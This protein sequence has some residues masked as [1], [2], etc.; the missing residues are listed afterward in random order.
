MISESIT[1]YINNRYPRWMDYAEYH[2]KLAG[3]PDE[4][5][6]ILNEV[7]LS[8]MQKDPDHLV[9]LLDKKKQGYTEL[10]F[11]LLA[12]IKL[13][14]HSM[15]SPYRHKTKDIP[16]DKNIDPWTIEIEDELSDQ[17]DRNAETLQ[18][19]RKARDIFEDLDITDK[20]KEIFS[21]RFFADNSL[22]SWPGPESYP[23]VCNI[24]KQVMSIMRE[25]KDLTTHQLKIRRFARVMVQVR[26]S[27]EYRFKVQRFARILSR[28]SCGQ[29]A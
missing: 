2:A 28:I 17:A 25:N 22:R 24:F 26:P 15:T 23:N 18:L 27:I 1:S 9:A 5:G 4:S 12:A 29:V 20:E 19:W 6:D 11:Y 8:L 13:N 21:W 3:I 7:L 14:A 16:K 10:D